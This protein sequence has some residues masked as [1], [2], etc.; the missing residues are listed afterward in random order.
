LHL[1]RTPSSL[2]IRG[3]SAQQPR[4]CT[5]VRAAKEIKI[6]QLTSNK[7]SVFEKVM[8]L[9]GAGACTSAPMMERTSPTTG[10]PTDM[11]S[12]TRRTRSSSA[13]ARTATSAC[14]APTSPCAMRRSRGSGSSS[15]AWRGCAWL[16]GRGPPPEACSAQPVNTRC[17]CRQ[18]SR[19]PCMT[20]C[21]TGAHLMCLRSAFLIKLAH[22]SGPAA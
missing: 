14:R 2:L 9:P 3:R 18:T 21:Q 4:S 7:G 12:W 17:H 8:V 5:V 20:T 13:P 6:T 22:S 10:L 11:A 16:A 15:S 19:P 1:C